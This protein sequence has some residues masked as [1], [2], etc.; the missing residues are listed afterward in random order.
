M[1]VVDERRRRM[2]VRS[3]KNG[4]GAVEILPDHFDPTAVVPEPLPRVVDLTAN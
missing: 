1:K 3:I 2:M 4:G